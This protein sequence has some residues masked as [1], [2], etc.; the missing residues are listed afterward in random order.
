MAIETIKLGGYVNEEVAKINAN[1]AQCV[2]ED[3]IPAVPTKVSDLT[4]DKGYQTEAEVSAIV[5]EAVGEISVPTKISELTNDAGFLKSN[6]ASF[7]NKVD[8]EAGKGLSTNDYTTAD[9]TKVGNIGKIDFTSA[10]FT[11]NA[12]DNL[13]YATIEANGKYPVKVMRQNGNDYEEVLVHAK[14]SGTNIVLASVE[15]FAG[16]VVTI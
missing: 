11:L 12:G 15:S 2:T 1:F 13:Y 10:Q 8:K 6:D 4:N 5:E 7:V 14:I 16:Y 3:D 9:K